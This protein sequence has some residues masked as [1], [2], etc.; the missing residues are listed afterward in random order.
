MTLTIRRLAPRDIPVAGALVAEQIARWHAMDAA[1]AVPQPA[2]RAAELIVRFDAQA[3]QSI[4]LVAEAGGVLAGYLAAQLQTLDPDSVERVWLPDRCVNCEVLLQMAVAAGQAW[5]DVFPPLWRALEA[6]LHLPPSFP[7]VLALVPAAAGL[8][9]LLGRLGFRHTSPFGYLPL[10]GIPARPEPGPG[11]RVRPAQAADRAA[12]LELFGELVEYH[13]ANDPTADRD[14]PLVLHDF[15]R[16]ITD[17][18]PRRWQLLVAE[19]AATPGT[20]LGFALGSVE[21]EESSPTYIPM[22]PTG[23]VG[24]VHEFTITAGARRRGVGRIYRTSN[25]TSSRFWP[26][27]GYRPLYQMWRRGGWA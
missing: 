26:G 9:A 19:E 11:V 27:V 10:D 13:V 24:F 21:V 15:A 1:V 18:N 22:L 12:V 8:D 16:L 4:S 5:D 25:P 17:L 14:H 6:A 23:P 3:E 7:V 20:L 2:Q